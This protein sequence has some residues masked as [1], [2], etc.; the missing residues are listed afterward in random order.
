MT[1]HAPILFLLSLI[2]AGLFLARPSNAPERGSKSKYI[3][4][5]SLARSDP[6]QGFERASAWL[7][8]GGGDAA[9]HCA[10]VSLIGLKQY[11]EA[12]KRLESLANMARS[13]AP[14]K[15]RI[16]GQAG[17]AWLLADKPK[18]AGAVLSAAIKLDETNPNFRIDRAQSA[19]AQRAFENAT[20]DLDAALSLDPSLTDAWV[21][22]ASAHRQSGDDIA[23]M[24]DIENALTLE[25]SHPEGLL[26]RG[27]LRRLQKNDSGARLDWLRVIE[28]AP[29]SDAAKSAQANLEKMDGGGQ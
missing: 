27:I 23:A 26:E 20:R 22:R 5:M 13:P 2:G 12:A 14:F 18:R 7:G 21:F 10:G 3:A 8:L 6:E 15:A 17:Q 16:L 1:K 19:A 29:D 9:R 25:K 11:P 24:K 4:C 28:L